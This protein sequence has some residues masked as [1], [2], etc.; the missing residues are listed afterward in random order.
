MT[1]M[2][3]RLGVVLSATAVALSVAALASLA[4]GSPLISKCVGA[5]SSQAALVVEHGDGRVV[6]RCVSFGSATV[7]GQALLESSGVSWSGQTFG[8]YGVAVCALDA[9]PLHYTACPGQDSYWAIFVSRGGAAWQLSSNGISSL[10]LGAGDAEGFRYVPAAGTPAA[11]PSPAGVCPVATA[12]PAAPATARPT[13]ASATAVAPKTA[14]SLPSATAGVASAMPTGE[15]SLLAIAAAP[16]SE[17]A[18]TPGPAAPG[19]AAAPGPNP[20]PG[21]GVDPGLVVAALAG[22]GLG[23]LALL[24]IAAA[25]RRAT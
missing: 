5:G 15:A 24:R 22:G 6:T 3:G 17:S 11:P 9:E 23:G 12:S 20:S 10:T 4:P 13:A 25:R 1:G 18:A 19:A 7:T 2:V 21:S 8:S 16:A 14:A